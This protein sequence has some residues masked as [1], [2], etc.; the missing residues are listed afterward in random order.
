MH[1]K[2][3]NITTYN[4]RRAIMA[5]EF[6]VDNSLL[7]QLAEYQI[8]QDKYDTWTDK[9]CEAFDKLPLEDK[10]D[11]LNH[12]INRR[13]QSWF[14]PNIEE[15]MMVYCQN[16]CYEIYNIDNDD[17]YQ[18][19]YVVAD[20]FIVTIWCDANTVAVRRIGKNEVVPKMLYEDRCNI[21]GP[22]DKLII[23]TNNRLCYLDICAQI[24]KKHLEGHYIIWHGQ[25]LEIN[26]DGSIVPNPPTFFGRART[27]WTKI[28]G[29]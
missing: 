19:E 11:F 23:S 15:M 25:R 8:E 1:G 5:K 7:Q 12:Y 22:D 28:Y 9:W 24:A 14:F 13:H 10:Q 4:R 26:P 17:D 18:M 3:K 16:Y 29:S 2:I 20:D 27:I 21:Y 6:K